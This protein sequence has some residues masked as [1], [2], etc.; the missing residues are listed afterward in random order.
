MDK[1]RNSDTRVEMDEFEL[2]ATKEELERADKWVRILRRG[3]K[4]KQSEW[5]LGFDA[6]TLRVRAERLRE[7]IYKGVPERVRSEVWQLLLGTSRLAFQ[8]AG[9][10]ERMRQRAVRVLDYVY[11]YQIDV[12]VNRCMRHHELFKDRYS[13]K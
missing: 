10:Y 1:L 3:E 2:R 9:M 5:H 11:V 7:L 4:G 8:Q 12:D 6:Q 13:P